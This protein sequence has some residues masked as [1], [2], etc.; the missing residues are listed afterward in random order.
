MFMIKREYEK[1]V[2]KERR[3]K[4]GGKEGA[5]VHSISCCTPN[6]ALKVAVLH[7]VSLST[8]R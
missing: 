4:E 3:G 8:H 2:E 5:R 6:T 1:E 7:C